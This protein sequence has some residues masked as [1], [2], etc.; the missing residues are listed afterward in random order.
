MT[1]QEIQARLRRDAARR[2][3]VKKLFGYYRAKHPI[4]ERVQS[5]ATKPNN[6]LAHGF[7]RYI[8][9]SYAGYMFGE[10]VT[11][12][13]EDE[14]LAERVKDAFD[15][16][17]EASENARLGLDCAVC[18]MAVELLYIDGDGVPRFARV[19]PEG[20]AYATDGTV[21]DN[22][23]ALIRYYDREDVVTGARTGTVEVYD[24]EKLSVYEAPGGI[25]HNEAH[26]RLVEEIPHA[27]GDVPAVVYRNNPDAMGDF[28]CVISLVDAYDLMQS[29]SLNDQEYFTDAYLKLKGIGEMDDETLAGMKR[30][31]VLLLPEDCDAEWMVKTQSDALP[32]NIKDRLNRD[33]HRF[34]GCPDMSDE[35]FAGNASGV[36]MRYKLLQFENNAGVKEREFKRG[37][38]RRIELLCNLWKKLHGEAMDWRAVKIEF[39]RSLPQ[40]LLELSQVVGNLGGVVSDETKRSWLPMDIDEDAEKAR[41]QEQYGGSLFTAM[42]RR[43]TVVEEAEAG[44]VTG[45]GAGR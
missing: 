38:Q 9:N 42:E 6:R 45:D 26:L 36:A 20:C 14:R 15:Y 10:P 28:E 13:S 43:T 30:N 8:A 2:E 11:Y 34:S 5:D 29:E 25:A 7:P 33:I 35:N 3:R 23:T 37:L 19:D 1:I 17:D 12:G 27:F 44:G 39:H 16:N 22:L 41:L 40:N 31:R 4:L 21:E 18:G 32:E 24:A